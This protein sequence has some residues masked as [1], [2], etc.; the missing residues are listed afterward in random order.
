MGEDD[1]K[2]K[3]ESH[4]SPYQLT[5]HAVGQGHHGG[6]PSEQTGIE[7][8]MAGVGHAISAAGGGLK[9]GEGWATDMVA[10]LLL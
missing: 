1:G 9:G 10:E 4:R 3:H 7:L 8:R 6:V 2:D 5:M